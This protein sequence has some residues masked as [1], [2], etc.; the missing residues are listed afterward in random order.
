VREGTC[1]L[2]RL[3]AHSAAL[4]VTMVASDEGLGS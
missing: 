3:F 2:E 1:L 4:S